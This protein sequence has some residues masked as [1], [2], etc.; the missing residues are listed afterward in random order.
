[1]RII[2]DEL[3]QDLALQE[4]HPFDIPSA[5]KNL[6]SALTFQIR[7]L[8]DGL[9]SFCLL[10]NIPVDDLGWWHYF[11]TKVESPNSYYPN[12]S[13]PSFLSFRK[14]LAQDIALRKIKPISIEQLVDVELRIYGGYVKLWNDIGINK[15]LS[16][17]GSSFRLA[18][19]GSK[20]IANSH[21]YRL[22]GHVSNKIEVDARFLWGQVGALT[23]CPVSPVF[24]FE[25]ELS[26]SPFMRGTASGFTHERR[27]FLRQVVM[28]TAIESAK[29]NKSDMPQEYVNKIQDEQG[30]RDALYAQWYHDF[31]HESIHL[32]QQTNQLGFPYMRTYWFEDVVNDMLRFAQRPRSRS[33]FQKTFDLSF[34]LPVLKTFDEYLGQNTHG[35]LN[36]RNV[37]NTLDDLL[38]DKLLVKKDNETLYSPIYESGIR[39]QPYFN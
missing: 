19:L 29:L 14:T 33:D 25:R 28:K 26:V 7:V 5:R 36:G 21:I 8:S 31:T 1:M 2:S 16:Q 20:S 15:Q 11:L 39:W 27:I 13:D 3:E 18:F 22:I 35:M 10:Q 24:D 38:R 6:E 23:A 34:N 17:L 30:F 12:L 32:V 37:D 9:M 4:K